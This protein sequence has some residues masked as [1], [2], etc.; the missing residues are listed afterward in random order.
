MAGLCSQQAM[1][2]HAIRSLDHAG[3]RGEP[4]TPDPEHRLRLLIVVAHGSPGAFAEAWRSYAQI[5][6]AR[7]GAAAALRNP[8]V[9]RVAI[10][11]DGSDTVAV[12][13]LRLVQWIG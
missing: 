1:I 4:A 2:E 8:Q 9:L 13:P 5:E 11:E 12:T 7:A 6:D 3:T 10:V